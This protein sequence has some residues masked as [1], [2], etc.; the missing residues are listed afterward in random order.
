MLCEAQLSPRIRVAAIAAHFATAS[1]ILDQFQNFLTLLVK[2][3]KNKEKQL[4]PITCL[5]IITDVLHPQLLYLSAF[6]PEANGGKVMDHW[7]QLSLPES[8]HDHRVCLRRD[9]CGRTPWNCSFTVRC[10]DGQQLLLQSIFCHRVKGARER[11][12]HADSFCSALM[13]SVR[14]CQWGNVWL[15]HSACLALSSIVFRKKKKSG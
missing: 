11:V 5:S 15:E 4:R 12:D 2:V 3:C 13:F 9:S 8:W 7:L 10:P 1:Y 14:S 6:L